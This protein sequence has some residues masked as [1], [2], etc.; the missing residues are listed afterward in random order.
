MNQ[1][2]T[3]QYRA[4]D[5]ILPVAGFHTF[6]RRNEDLLSSGRFERELAALRRYHLKYVGAIIVSAAVGCEFLKDKES[7]EMIIDVTQIA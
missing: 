4:I 7:L 2:Q 3:L 6:S 5:Y 1:Q